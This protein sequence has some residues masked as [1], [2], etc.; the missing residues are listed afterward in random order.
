MALSYRGVLWFYLK[1]YGLLIAYKNFINC[2][3]FIVYL[4]M[5][6]NLLKVSII[7]IRKSHRIENTLIYNFTK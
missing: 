4:K 1:N 2:I 6:Q 3:F 5:L 7:K